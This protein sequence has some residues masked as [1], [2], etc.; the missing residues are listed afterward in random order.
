MVELLVGFVVTIMAGTCHKSMD[1][2]CLLVVPV[3]SLVLLIPIV[4]LKEIVV[5]LPVVRLQVVW[6]LVGLVKVI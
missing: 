5:W 4:L 2:V 3:I 1:G 6:Q